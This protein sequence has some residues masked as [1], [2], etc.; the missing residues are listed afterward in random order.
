MKGEIL[1]RN[2]LRA[3]RWAVGFAAALCLLSCSPEHAPAPPEAGT[4]VSEESRDPLTLLFGVYTTDTPAEA[5]KKFR[6]LLNVL[7]RDL[8]G[9]LGQAVR[10]RT[11]VYGDYASGL[12]AVVSDKVDF[13]RLGPAS[14]VLASQRSDDVRLLAMETHKGQK[15]FYGVLCVHADSELAEIEDLAGLRVA[16]GDKNS[17][18]GRY[19]SQQLLRE[20]GVRAEDLAG[21]EYLGRHDLV[22]HAVGM[23]KFDVGA[24]KESTFRKLVE[25]GVPIRELARFPNVTKPWVATGRLDP[26]IRASLREALLAIRDPDALARVGKTPFSNASPGDYEPVRRSL[27]ENYRFFESTTH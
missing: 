1:Q 5:V 24:L 27:E 15:T 6:P 4:P 16:F 3:L 21:F 22:G 8:S 14:Y 11:D 2:A 9:A 17:T 10:I 19:L 12:D 7:E 23:G 25:Q 18:I 20:R 26:E 13:A